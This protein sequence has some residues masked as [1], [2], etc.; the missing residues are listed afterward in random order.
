MIY[1]EEDAAKWVAAKLKGGAPALRIEVQGSGCSGYKYVFSLADK[2]EADDKVVCQGGA[3]VAIDPASMMLLQGSS[4]ILE[5]TQ[6]KKELKLINPN[7]KSACGCGQSF[8]V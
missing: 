3:R 1:I 5:S 4:L 6:F 7:V 2:V 8:S